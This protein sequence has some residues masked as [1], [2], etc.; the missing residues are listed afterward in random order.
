MFMK[1][2]SKISNI[3]A[4]IFVLLFAS[5]DRCHGNNEFKAFFEFPSVQFFQTLQ[6]CGN[7]FEKHFNVKTFC[8]ISLNLMF[9][10]I[11]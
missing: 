6:S 1:F 5:K 7:C 11:K 8:Q 10:N 3:L 9:F 4:I 2:S